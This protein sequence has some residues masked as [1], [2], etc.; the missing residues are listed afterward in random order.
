MTTVKEMRAHIARLCKRHRI[1]HVHVARVDDGFADNQ[2]G[3]RTIKAPPIKSAISYA[4]ALHEIGHILSG[5][6][7][8][9]LFVFEA[10]AWKW[11]RGAALCWTPAMAR[12]ARRSLQSY[13]DWALEEHRS[14]PPRS[15][16]AWTFVDF[17]ETQPTWLNEKLANVPWQKVVQHPD[18]PRCGT[19]D[20]WR[21]H[22]TSTGGCAWGA[23]L[24]PA[25]PM[26]NLATPSS[27]FCGTEYKRRLPLVSPSSPSEKSPSAT[28]AK[29]S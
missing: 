25:S 20:Y 3:N 16:Y 21:H 19:C 28:L 18:H 24:H 2:R 6:F 29:S 22:H 12:S 14:L 17:P 4:C 26:G 10:S 27:A 9:S 5:N 11:A 8:A 7:G 1:R 15:H 13:L 23:C